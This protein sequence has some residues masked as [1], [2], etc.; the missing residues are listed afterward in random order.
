MDIAAAINLESHSVKNYLKQ[1]SEDWWV[2]IKA[3]WNTVDTLNIL[4][5]FL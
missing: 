4:I 2:Y 5:D 3:S 1:L